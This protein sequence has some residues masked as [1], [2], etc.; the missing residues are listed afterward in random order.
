MCPLDNVPP[1]TQTCMVVKN[2]A[3]VK[4]PSTAV[5]L[6]IVLSITITSYVLV[7]WKLKLMR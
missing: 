3:I 7:S 2:S 5:L 4:L 1:D 6:H